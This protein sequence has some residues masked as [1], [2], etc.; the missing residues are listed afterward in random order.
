[1][2]ESI[3]YA[4]IA[5]YELL[6]SLLFALPRHRF[7]NGIKS[8]FINVM[9]G[10]AHKR[11]VYYPGV[12]IIPLHKI[13]LGND[14]DLA[15]GV[16][17][18]TNGGVS[19]GDRTLV[20]YNSVILSRNHTIPENKGQMFS[21]GHIPAPVNIKNDVWIGANCTI[22]PGVKIGEGAIIAAGSVV[23][24]DVDA[25]TIVAGNPAKLIRKR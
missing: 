8:S 12:R 3:R 21:A 17:I 19:I 16:I 24:K 11:V 15:W 13:E 20:G 9:G 7:T 14:V 23:T 5:S 10:R 4:L 22:L 25:F 1:V 2:I 18:T 6:F